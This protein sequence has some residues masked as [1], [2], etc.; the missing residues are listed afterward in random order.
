MNETTSIW[1]QTYSLFGLGIGL[2][3]L[4]AAL[5]IFTLLFLLGVLRKQAWFA[6]VCGLA[7][8]LLLATLGYGMPVK[9]AISASVYGGAFGL[10]PICWIIFWAIA[11]FRVT[12][13]T[14]KFEIIRNSI[15]RVSPDPRMQ[16]LLVAFCFGAFLEGGAGFGTPVAVA[17]TMLAG[18][19]FPAFTAAAI[20]LLANTAPVAF[21]AMGIPVITLAG[22][23]GLPLDKLSRDVAL[24]C[25]PFSLILPVYLLVA[26]GGFGAMSGVWVPALTAGFTFTA[27]QL[28]LS[29]LMGPQLSA[30][31]AALASLVALIV[32]LRLRKNKTAA[33]DNPALLAFSRRCG[34][35]V[36]DAAPVGSTLSEYSFGQILYAWIP[37]VLLVVCVLLWSFGPVQRVLNRGSIS[38]QWPWLHDVVQRMP[39]ITSAPAPYHALFS[40][41]FLPAAG[42]ACMTA[43]FL[44]AICLK[45]RPSRFL[46][47]LAAVLHQLALPIATVVVVLGVGFL[48][49][50][51]GGTATLGL[52]FASTRAWFPFF[53][54]F[55]G[56]LGVFLT[57]SDTS[58]NALFGGLQTI[59]AGRLGL[60]PVL[61]AAANAAGGVMGKMISVQTIAVAAAATGL[62][63]PAQASLF[64]F[65][66]KHS[67]LLGLFV[68][69]LV[70]FYSYVLRI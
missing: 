42:T 50:Y 22:T 9:A 8:A 57:G 1:H 20:C 41:N 39:P 66:L 58:S 10:F 49:N 5:P 7:A 34:F 48:M 45:V 2:S 67:I 37:Y 52:A 27:I 65:T 40:F 29:I 35:S 4:I 24:L 36:P 14:G 69:G 18:M 30:I 17:A 33:S 26:V 12:V 31:L 28:L 25:S 64:R 6:G 11:L 3:A 19:G 54:P 56:L 38:F 63:V 60:D 70:V 53:S 23:T 47:I 61:M 62:A 15:E 13:E 55:L 68:A 46:R 32:V 59:T 21:G 16:A 51:C 43:T 44:T